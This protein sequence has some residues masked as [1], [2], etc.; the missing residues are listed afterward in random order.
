MRPKRRF[1]FAPVLDSRTPWVRTTIRSP[2]S[3][4]NDYS[5]WLTTGYLSSGDGCEILYM[6]EATEQFESL[7]PAVTFTADATNSTVT[8]ATAHFSRWVIDK[9]EGE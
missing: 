4:G 6:N 9:G 7:S 2:S 8:F 1:K 5:R 3:S